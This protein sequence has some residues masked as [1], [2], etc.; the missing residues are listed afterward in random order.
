MITIYCL[1]DRNKTFY[2]GQ[3][4]NLSNR[5]QNHLSRS[6]KYNDIKSKMI[7]KIIESGRQLKHK[8]L[9]NCHPDKANELER[10]YI[11]IYRDNGCNII[12]NP[13][14]A[15]NYKPSKRKI[16]NTKLNIKQLKILQLMADDLR[17]KDI[18]INTGLSSRTVETIIGGIKKMYNKVTITGLLSYA[19]RNEIVK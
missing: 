11:Q 14:L 7:R 1:Q 3:T 15:A 13:I 2:I 18:A 17:A 19:Y 16:D 9:E 4:S 8:V 12:N 6:K 10:Y 5:L